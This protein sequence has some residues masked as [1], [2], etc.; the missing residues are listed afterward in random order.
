MLL[1]MKVLATVL[2]FL[3]LDVLVLDVYWR[4]KDYNNIL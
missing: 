4:F 3:I 1:G 2:V